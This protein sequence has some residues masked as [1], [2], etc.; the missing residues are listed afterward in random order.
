MP[1]SVRAPCVDVVSLLFITGAKHKAHLK[2]AVITITIP[3][4]CGVALHR[5]TSLQSGLLGAVNFPNVYCNL[6]IG[7]N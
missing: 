3:Q 4:H 6:R 5:E 7:R 1:S 2:L